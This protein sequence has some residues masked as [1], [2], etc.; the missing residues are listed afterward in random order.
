MSMSPDPTRWLGTVSLTRRLAVAIA[1]ARKAAGERVLVA[2]KLRAAAMAPVVS[3]QAV[4]VP[5]YAR[6]QSAGPANWLGAQ[7]SGLTDAK[8]SGAGPCDE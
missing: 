3:A 2:G 5:V 1:R 4:E 7:R 8:F 6:P